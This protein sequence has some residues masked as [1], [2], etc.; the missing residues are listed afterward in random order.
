MKYVYSNTSNKWN[1]R[2]MDWVDFALI[3]ANLIQFT[4]I[5]WIIL[6]LKEDDNLWKNKSIKHRG[7]TKSITDKV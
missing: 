1:K 5:Y 6:A 7:C 4:I 2:K 3:L